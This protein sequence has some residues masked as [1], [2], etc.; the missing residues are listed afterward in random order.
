MLS[1][2]RNIDWRSRRRLVGKPALVPVGIGGIVGCEGAAV[3]SL[4]VGS[5]RGGTRPPQCHAGR[6]RLRPRR[7]MPP[8][9][10]EFARQ[11]AR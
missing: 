11:G 8:N 6:R 1:C 10:R 7:R 4:G 2:F 3:R 9:V 5:G